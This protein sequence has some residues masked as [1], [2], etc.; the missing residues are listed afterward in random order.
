MAFCPRIVCFLSMFLYNLFQ[1]ILYHMFS[2]F[3]SYATNTYVRVITTEISLN[4]QNSQDL[5][6][7][8]PCGQIKVL[9]TDSD[10]IDISAVH[11]DEFRTLGK[12]AARSIARIVHMAIV[13]L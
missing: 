9:T 1:I 3:S 2:S 4:T 11:P 6:T 13:R 10:V 5:F 8:S 12:H 7:P